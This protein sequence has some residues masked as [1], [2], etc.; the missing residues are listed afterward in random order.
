MYHLDNYS[1]AICDN[2]SILQS[3]QRT[4]HLHIFTRGC[5]IRDTL[6]RIKY[7]PKIIKQLRTTAV[8]GIFTE[9][10]NFKQIFQIATV[11]F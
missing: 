7:I 10:Y 4:L 8:Y 11:D 9:I 6:L 3:T 1:F 5:L 2:C